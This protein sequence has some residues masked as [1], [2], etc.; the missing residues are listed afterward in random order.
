[1]SESLH[2]RFLVLA[3]G[4]INTYLNINTMFTEMRKQLSGKFI[5]QGC[6]MQIKKTSTVLYTRF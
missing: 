1:M 6:N 5:N 2:S 4:D 3:G